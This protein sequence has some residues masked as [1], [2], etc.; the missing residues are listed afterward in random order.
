MSASLEQAAGMSVFVVGTRAQLI[1]VAPVIV[2]CQ[3]WKLPIRLL[4]TGQ[5]QETMQ[6]LL[7]EFGVLGPPEMLMPEGE[8]ATV[9]SLVR[10]LPRAYWALRQRLRRMREEFGTI[11]VVVHGDTLSTVIGAL[12]AKQTGN[13]VF[14]LES[15]LSSGRLFDPFP[16]ELSRR[17]VFRW[18]DVAFCPNEE[19]ASYMRQNSRS[20]VVDTSGNTIIDAVR[21]TGALQT[22]TASKDIVVSLHRF[23]NIFNSS[24]LLQ[25]VQLVEEVGR[26]YTVHFVLHPATRKR[27][28]KD[29]LLQ[30]LEQHEGVHL[31]PRLGYRAFLGLAANAACVLT[32]GG[33]N[34]EEL[35]V[36]GVP[37]IIMRERT[38]RPDG[39]GRNALMEANLHEGVA[40]FIL[41][42]HYAELRHPPTQAYGNSPSAIVA[43]FLS[44]RGNS[45]AALR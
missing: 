11:S 36:L 22:N 35:S 4:L 2:A 26:R 18:T 37:T 20:L 28:T 34:Q 29:G 27:L 23:Q 19:A 13:R 7:R 40:E 5:H 44:G 39:L 24:R 6:D 41:S 43:S 45:A 14:H 17:L 16:E 3:D 21:L 31:S 25:L 10:W 1:K 9:S 42:G 38:E 15:G 12:A 8:K 32:D 33:S 30:R